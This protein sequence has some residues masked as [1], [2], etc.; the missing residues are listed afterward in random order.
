MVGERW[1]V[2]RDV[3]AFKMHQRPEHHLNALHIMARL[4][5]LGVCRP[6]AL[7]VA[8]WWESLAHPWLYGA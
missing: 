1:S 7:M 3:G 5:E 4:T 6:C 8:P 2:G